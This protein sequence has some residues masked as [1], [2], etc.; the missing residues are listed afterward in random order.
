MRRVVSL[1][2]GCCWRLKPTKWACC[3]SLR[4][5][6]SFWCRRSYSS[7]LRTCFTTLLP[8]P[9]CFC[10]R[11]NGCTLCLASPSVCPSVCLRVQTPGYVPKKTWWVFF[12]YIHLKNPG[13][14]KNPHFYFNLIL[15]YTL[16]ATNNAIFFLKLLRNFSLYFI[17]H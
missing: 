4:A 5:V 10:D 6:R 2:G 13:A 8:H 11:S 14:P 9:V 16:Y 1:W 17:C 3:A 7:S 12:G 15:A